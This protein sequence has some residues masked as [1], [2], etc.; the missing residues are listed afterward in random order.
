MVVGLRSREP[1]AHCVQTPRIEKQQVERNTN[2]NG[3]YEK[4]PKLYNDE[5]RLLQQVAMWN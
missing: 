3:S 5:E 1:M 4:T 2:S